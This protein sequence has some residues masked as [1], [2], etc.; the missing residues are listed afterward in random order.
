MYYNMWVDEHD[1]GGHADDK[2]SGQKGK[3][4]RRNEVKK[5]WP[6]S[7]KKEPRTHLICHRYFRVSKIKKF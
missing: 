7:D 6:C 3:R 5:V 1:R 2:T 4:L